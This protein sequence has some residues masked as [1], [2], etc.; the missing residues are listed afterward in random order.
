M[1]WWGSPEV[2]YFFCKYLEHQTT[3]DHRFLAWAAWA[4]VKLTSL[5]GSVLMRADVSMAFFFPNPFLFVF[6]PFPFLS[7]RFLLFRLVSIVWLQA[8]EAPGVWRRRA[9]GD[10]GR[11]ETPGVWRRRASGDAGRLETPGVWRRRA[12]GDAGHLETPGVW[13]RRASGGTGHPESNN[14]QQREAEG[15]K[16]QGNEQF[17]KKETKGQERERKRNEKQ[18]ERKDIFFKRDILI[19]FGMRTAEIEKTVTCWQ[20]TSRFSLMKSCFQLVISIHFIYFIAFPHFISITVEFMCADTMDQRKLPQ[21]CP[22]AVVR[23]C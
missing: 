2:K 13:R 5:S 20:H 18:R 14:R 12:S 22:E 15:N 10:A 1:S 11:P 17:Y 6:F 23:P 21:Q 9:S 3:P 8:P 19:I 4:G 7:F 16:K